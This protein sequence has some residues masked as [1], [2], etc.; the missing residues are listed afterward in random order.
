[1]TETASPSK[2]N[3]GKEPLSLAP[4]RGMRDLLPKETALRDWATRTILETYEQFGFSRIETPVLEHLQNLKGGEG[5]ENLKLIYEVLKR[6]EKLDKVLE[7]SPV[8][9]DQLADLG[10]RFD[11]TVPLVRYFC[12]NQNDLLFPMK[13]IQIG[14]V[15]RAEAPQKGRFRQFTQCDIDILGVKSAVAETE[16]LIASAAA[17]INLGFKDFRVRINDRRLLTA[18]VA[19]C[20]F[21]G[22]FEPVFIAIDKL[23]KIGIDGVGKDLLEH[24][25][26][27][28]AVEKLKAILTA[29]QS[30]S[31]DLTTFAASLQGKDSNGVSPE[32]S[33]AMQDLSA[34][35]DGVQATAENQY[36]IVFDPTLVRGMGYY[37]GPIFEI[38]MKGYSYSMGGGGRYDNMVGKFSGREVP[39]CGFSIGFERIIGV[40]MDQG[41]KPKDSREK[42]ALIFDPDRDKIAD[43]MK[44]AAKLRNHGYSV[45]AHPRKKDM[46][47]QLDAFLQH[48]F[49]KFVA[50]RGE[51]DNLEIKTLGNK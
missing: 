16:L 31:A 6:G 24:G 17:L 28:E 30:E 37:T 45:S 34:V 10:M 4:P 27:P 41:A 1:M 39:A 25:H 40:M 48:D 7:A 13:A 21:T 2:P 42:L 23:D 32:L 20:G 44:A 15:W 19:H 9:R 46:K 43:V 18:M 36:D 5:G 12:A 38:G 35:I 26:G 29:S 3:D 11:L 50:F 49:A 8:E 47:K 14:S 51:V 33:Q 22:R